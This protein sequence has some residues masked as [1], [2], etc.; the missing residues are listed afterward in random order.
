ML[1]SKRVR[2]IMSGIALAALVAGCERV[3]PGGPYRQPDATEVA[4][5]A[6]F[7]PVAPGEQY[8]PNEISPVHMVADAPVSTFAVDV[9]TAAY[10]NVRRFLTQGRMPP[11]DAVRTEEMIN[12][13]RYDYP[14]PADRTAPFSVTT[15]VAQSPWNPDTKLL[16]IGLR[17]YDLSYAKRPAANLIFLVDVSGSMDEPDKLPLV[18]TALAMLADRIGPEDRVG[19]VV[20]AGAAGVVLDPTGDPAEIRDA[21][22]QLSAGGSTAGGEGLQLAYALAR[23]HFVKGGVNRVLLATD[24][25]FNVGITDRKELEQ[26]IE[27]ERDDGIT[28]TTLGFGQGNLNDAM[29]E[30]I[31]DLGNGNYAYIDSAMEAKKVLSEELSSTLFTIAKDVKIQVEFNPHYISQYRLIGYEN[32][33]LAE[34]D[35]ADDKVD[36]GDI[37]A[38]HQVTALYEVVPAGASGWIADRR[39]TDNR[40]APAA[41]AGEAGARP[42]GEMAFVR[43]R[44]KL[45]DG[46]T[47]RLIERPVAATMLATHALPQGDMAFATAVAAFG[48]KLRGDTRLGDIGF[49]DIRRLAGNPDGYWRQE[50]VKLTEL[51]EAGARPEKRVVGYVD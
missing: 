41:R 24:G 12:Y 39:Y 18:K 38:G 7:Q 2:S 45:P 36:A 44:Y 50:F 9:D 42:N 3:Q 31:A 5:D 1:I 33:A 46:D 40:A 22:D 19:I 25:D 26:L 4:S 14:L 13:F 17:G 8:K 35:F 29:M 15:D 27:R 6:A 11:K 16:R 30:S 47:S 23:D 32:R 43:L 49:G 10:S 21:L 37:G 48:Q 28:L 51:A 34:Q 20:Y